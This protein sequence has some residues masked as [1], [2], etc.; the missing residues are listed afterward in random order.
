MLS[1]RAARRA[2]LAPRTLHQ[3]HSKDSTAQDRRLVSGP[4]YYEVV[5]PI[6]GNRPKIVY[7]HRGGR[8]RT[9]RRRQR[10]RPRHR[11]TRARPRV[12]PDPV[13]GARGLL[14]IEA[15]DRNGNV[16]IHK[17][18]SGYGPRATPSGPHRLRPLRPPVVRMPHT[19]PLQQATDSRSRS[20]SGGT[21]FAR[22]RVTPDSPAAGLIRHRHA[23]IVCFRRVLEDGAPRM[24]AAGGG[25][26]HS[27]LELRGPLTVSFP[28]PVLVHP[29]FDGCGVSTAR[30]LL[31]NDAR[32][33]H[34]PVEFAFHE[35]GPPL[36]R[37]AGSGTLIVLFVQSMRIERYR[38]LLRH[39]PEGIYPSARE[40]RKEPARARRRAREPAGSCSRGRDRRLDR[41]P[42][43]RRLDEGDRWPAV[44]DRDGRRADRLAARPWR[45]GFVRLRVSRSSPAA[46]AI[47]RRRPG[48]L[49]GGTMNGSPV[50]LG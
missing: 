19:E 3:V 46:P 30:G 33:T 14:F 25:K 23:A 2:G 47:R 12:H 43:A 28:F 29:P 45:N 13:P 24:Y 17:G 38:W 9:R 22:L 11:R 35:G 21:R 7:R 1:A 34:L 27:P 5:N 10:R 18:L 31:W 4:L 40:L 41:R 6:R 32:G 20:A 39:H 42:S 36:L 26:A 16:V 15:L 8:H 50:F 37:R 48:S 49:F 44:P